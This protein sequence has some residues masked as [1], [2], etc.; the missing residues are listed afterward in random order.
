MAQGTITTGRVIAVTIQPVEDPSVPVVA[1]AA[2]A[3]ATALRH[4]M[5][6]LDDPSH[7]GPHVTMA[8]PTRDGLHHLQRLF[9]GL[10][11]RTRYHN[12]DV[13]VV[14]NDSTDDTRTWLDETDHPFPVTVVANQSNESFSRANN[15]AL[16]V[17]SGPLFLAINNDVDPMHPD[18][19]TRLVT[20]LHDPG[21]VAVGPLLVY[22]TRPPEMRGQ[23]DDLTVQHA[24]IAFRVDEGRVRAVNREAGSDPLASR[25]RAT[26]EVAGLTAACLLVRTDDLRDLGGFDEGYDWGSEDWDLSLRLARRGRLLLVGRSTLFHHEFGTQHL[27]DDDDI[28]A[29]RIANHTRFNRRCGAALRRQ[30]LMERLRHPDQFDDCDDD[31]NPQMGQVARPRVVIPGDDP[32]AAA[33]AADFARRGWD[34]ADTDT[35]FDLAVVHQGAVPGQH[36]Q[37]TV[38]A[39]ISRGATDQEL[40]DWVDMVL[41]PAGTHRAHRSQAVTVVT[42][43]EADLNTATGVTAA[44]RGQLARPRIAVRACPPNW[45]KARVWGDTHFAHSFATALRGHGCDTAV[46]VMSDWDQPW[47]NTFDIVIHLR[48]LSAQ[49]I[50]PGSVNVMWLISHPELVTDE[51]LDSY[52]LVL[53]ASSTFAASLEDRTDTPIEVAWQATD[54]TTFRPTTRDRPRDA[55]GIVV[56]ASARW[57]SRPGAQWLRDMGWEFSLQGAH[58]TRFSH[59]MTADVGFVPN[60]ELTHVYGQ[61]DIVVADQWELMARQGFVANRLFDV[62]A[63]GGFVISDGGPGVHEVFGDMVPTYDNHIELHHLLLR[64]YDDPAARNAIVARA[65]PYV[66]RHHSFDAR[67]RQVLGLLHIPPPP[68]AP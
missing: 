49:P 55:H 23:H 45:D 38:T 44:V 31:A 25:H 62:L 18:W 52:D 13:V 7:T 46:Q 6:E 37:A 42:P 56:V 32:D 1:D 50:S 63:S 29:R 68:L 33:L 36:P 35:N 22:P 21:G 39:A 66:R 24:G 27:D 30:L 34:L 61:A 60:D 3:L 43:A 64:Y 51:E 28:R 11:T 54:T 40:P 15:Q 67:A 9:D 5:L 53:V 20:T 10:A 16:E 58:W 19:L 26:R 12:F 47:A 59:N 2:A 14:D 65:M 57:P 41:R 48:G 17:A 8:V 4:P